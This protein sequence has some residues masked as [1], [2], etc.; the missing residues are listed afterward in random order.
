MGDAASLERAFTN[1]VG[2]AIKYSPEDTTIAIML[3]GNNGQAKLTVD[4]QGVGIDPG[5]LGQLFTRFKRDSTTAADHQGIGL[6]LAL[7]SQVVGLHSGRVWASNLPVGTRI[8]LTLPLE[9]Q[10]SDSENSVVPSLVHND[11]HDV[12]LLQGAQEA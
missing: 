10:A 1:I 6:G 7:V 2:N 9:V 8:T 12:D 3:V 11:V 4:D 5:M